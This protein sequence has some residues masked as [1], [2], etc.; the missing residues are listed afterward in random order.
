MDLGL[1]GKVAMVAAASKGLGFAAARELAREG[2]RV[3][4]CGRDEGRIRDAADRIAAETGAEVF[5]FVADVTRAEDVDRWVDAV[6]ERWGTVHVLVTNAGG[7][8]A[9][10]FEDFDD[11]AWRRAQELNFFSALRLIRRVLPKMRQQRWGRIVAITSIAVKQ[12]IDGLILSN[13]VRAGLT[14]MLRTLA[15]EVAAEGIT[16]NA[17][18]PGWT[19][20]ERV[21]ELFQARAKAQGTTPEAVEEAIAGQIPARR[22][23]RPEELAALIAFLAS[24]RA[25]FITAA[26]IP[27]DGGFARGLL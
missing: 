5:P 6:L 2:A 20:T 13:S 16:V 17:V 18:M 22:L 1:A 3:S 7:P 19:R 27:C 9:G 8:P 24:E 25:S 21:V 26:S 10:R 4:L 11:E 14:G 23:G 12:P 15:N